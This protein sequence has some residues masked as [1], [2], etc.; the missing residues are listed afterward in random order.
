MIW[1]TQELKTLKKALVLIIKII[2]GIFRTGYF[3]SDWK[4]AKVIP[5]GKKDKDSS[6]IG[7][8][9]SIITSKQSGRK[10]H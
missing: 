10:N 9:R 3:P 5:T 2:N 8:Y 7:N 4:T 6:K 1:Y